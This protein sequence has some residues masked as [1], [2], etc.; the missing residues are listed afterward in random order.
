MRVGACVGIVA[1]V[2]FIVW[3][4]YR[5]WGDIVRLSREADVEPVH[6]VEWRI[7]ELPRDEDRAA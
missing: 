4:V 6:M 5:H 1:L 7:A 3:E 2:A